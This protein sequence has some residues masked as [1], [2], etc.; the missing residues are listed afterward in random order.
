MKPYGSLSGSRPGRWAGEG[1]PGWGWRLCGPSLFWWPPPGSGFAWSSGKPA[2]ALRSGSLL[3]CSGPTLYLDTHKTRCF[4][5]FFLFIFPLLT[6]ISCVRCC[7]HEI[8]LPGGAGYGLTSAG[9]GFVDELSRRIE[10]D[11]HVKGGGVVGLD[12]VIGDVHPRVV[13]GSAAPFALGTVEDVR[14]AE[15]GQLTSVWGDI[16]AE[17]CQRITSPILQ[18]RL[19]LNVGI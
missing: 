11:A 2:P 4:S 1:N 13:L 9:E 8:R 15:F 18:I 3:R 12:A 19:K 10:V 17:I 14:N 6:H 16:P 7:F 5:L